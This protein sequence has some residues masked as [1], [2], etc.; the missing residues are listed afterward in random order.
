MRELINKLNQEV[1][2]LY[3]TNEQL[4][5]ENLELEDSTRKLQ[6]AESALSAIS[7]AQ[8]MSIDT[9]SKQVDEYR[10]IQKKIKVS[11]V[12]KELF[13]FIY[14]VFQHEP[15]LIERLEC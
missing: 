10:E 7:D 8:G 11:I 3:A 14:V 15:P 4:K 13:F 6:K 1:N 2:A 5:E 9:L 12:S